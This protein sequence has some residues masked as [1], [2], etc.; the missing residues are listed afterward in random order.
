[1]RK[2]VSTEKTPLKIEIGRG[3]ITKPALKTGRKGVE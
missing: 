3:I 1:V 2:K